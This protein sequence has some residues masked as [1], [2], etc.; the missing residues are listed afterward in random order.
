MSLF[1]LLFIIF[2]IWYIVSDSAY[3]KTDYYKTTHKSFV[4][5]RFD[6]G[7]FGEYLTYKYLRKFEEDGARFLYNCYLPK[8]NGETT[9]VDVMM[10]H[11]SGIYVFESK[12]Y[13]GWIFGSEDS[14]NWTQTL[15]SGRKAHKEHFLNPIIQNK[16]HIKWLVKLIGE[17]APIHSI[18]VFSERCTL[19]KIDLKS[20]GI[21]VIKRNVVA[22]VVSEI[23]KRTGNVLSKE[24]VDTLYE[25]LYPYT[26]TTDM[27]RERHVQDIKEKYSDAPCSQHNPFVFK[28]VTEDKDFI[29]PKCGGKLV[30]RVSKRGNYA[31]KSFYGCGNYPKCRYIKNLENTNKAE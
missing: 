10:I 2:L 9:E 12:N 31:G 17:E 20:T 19:K 5:M 3:K 16:V 11:Q 27:L 18:I 8:E 15:P 23:N 26:Q 13:S 30:K 22:Q 28:E 6:T 14:K 1:V 29:C 21:Y 7:N 4:A 24:Q 25:K